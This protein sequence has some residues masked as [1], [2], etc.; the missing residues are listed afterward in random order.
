M[1]GRLPVPEP[2]PELPDLD[3]L[4]SCSTDPAELTVLLREQLTMAD[5]GRA[6]RFYNG[7][8]VARLVCER[9]WCVEQLLLAA[10]TSLIP[11]SAGLSLLAVGGFGRGEL[12]PYSDIDLLILTEKPG[13]GSDHGGALEVLVRVLWDAGLALG[14][15][16][17]SLGECAE[18]AASD[19]KFATNLMESR[20]L[21]GPQSSYAD[22]LEATGPARIW[23]PASFFQAK[24]SEQMARYEQYNL[25][26]YNLEPNIKE[27]P[28]GLRDIQMVIWVAKRLLDSATLEAM[29]S[30]GFLAP[31]EYD[32]LINGL[33]FLWKIRFA[34]HLEAGR[35]EDRLLF[36]YQREI[37]RRFGFKEDSPGNLAVEQF[38]Q[39]YY[40]RVMQLERLNERLLQLFDEQLLQPDNDEIQALSEDFNA[41][42]GYLEVSDDKLF[43]RKPLALLELFVVLQQNFDIKGIRA[44]TIRLI[45]H[46]RH[47]IDEEFRANPDAQRMFMSV[48][49]QRR[50]VYTQLQRM[51]RY[52][53]LAQYVPAFAAI[54][55]R[56]QF[57]LFH[58]Y[59]VDQHSLFVIRNL[60]RFA[61]GKY[62]ERFP[63]GPE[64]FKR[65]DKPELLYLAALFHDIAKGRGGDH[66]DLGA[67][68]AKQF[69]SEHGVEPADQR[70]VSWLVQ[71]HLLMSMT[72]QRKDI[73]DP[74]IIHEFAV[75]TGDYRH[76]NYLYLL[77]MADIAATSPKL[78]NTWKDGLLWQL[79]QET[80]HALRRGLENPVDRELIIAETRMAT[81]AQ[82]EESGFDPAQVKELWAA[83]PAE[84][85]LQ[86]SPDQLAWAT[87]GLLAG[88]PLPAVLIR[89]RESLGVSEV[90]IFSEDYTGLF[91]A[92]TGELEIMMLNI[93]S[94][95]VMT[96]DKGY[97]FNLFQI[98][99]AAHE[100]LNEKDT[101]RLKQSLLA[102]LENRKLGSMPGGRVPRRL[103]HFMGV[104]RINFSVQPISG[105]SVMELECTD[106][107]GL[108]SRVAHVFVEQGISVHDARIATFGDRVEDTFMLSTVSGEP[109]DVASQE[110]LRKGIMTSLDD[111]T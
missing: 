61:Y 87:S 38:M 32:A 72:A 79:Y 77:T 27:G 95:R 80:S 93:L 62:L 68:D 30:H 102:V 55:G 42:K 31:I 98:M 103:K 8:D 21:A 25:T 75:K 108:L 19:I 92:V 52:G 51:N 110:R 53:L 71:N 39:E 81:M 34:L 90:L 70:L 29:V 44:A 33:H 76:L 83:L 5:A 82:L 24:Y 13:A 47:R 26:A 7:E 84:A 16:V 1:T 65:I 67:V 3:A 96:S 6:A 59:T 66:A 74:A 37:A 23:P 111:D 105:F 10:W 22:L 60:R 15:S 104:T 109:L 97:G 91:A 50:G 12:H 18:D 101:E 78:W 88:H 64:I 86:F 58:T 56:M 17:R 46:N 9:A 28:G 2:L 41:R 35:A 106:R 14:H 100:P 11:D 94:A 40:Q 57:D 20:L 89:N 48:L 63:H 4:D 45:R 54:T 43:R 107:P 73:A 49:R 99:D 85:A 36:E 69:C